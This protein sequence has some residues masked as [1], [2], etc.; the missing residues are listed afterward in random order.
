MRPGISTDLNALMVWVYGDTW[1]GIPSITVQ[2]PL[3]PGNLASVKLAF[4]VS[5]QNTAPVLELTSANGDIVITSAANWVFTVS[6]GIYDLP[7]GRYLWQIETTDDSSPA[8]IQTILE[9]T[10]EVLDNLTTIA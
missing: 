5:P 7:V 9:G 4:K 1:N 10:A 8:Y 3:A 6:S 2:N